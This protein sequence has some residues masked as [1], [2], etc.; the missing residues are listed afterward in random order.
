MGRYM[1]EL[2][3]TI[4]IASGIA[5]FY[6]P[7]V[8]ES[9]IANRV[10]WGEIVV[11]QGEVGYV[12][13]LDPDDIGR[14]V[15]LA[16]PAGKVIGPI[17]VVDCAGESDRERLLQAGW[18]V[19]LSFELAVEFDAVDGPVHGFKIWSGPPPVKE[20]WQVLE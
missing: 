2:V 7:G 19:D 18:A 1:S 6:A 5:T 11:G 14:M 13:L 9:V 4:L 12:A 3:S 17:L 8:M 20:P 10:D 15:W 16:H